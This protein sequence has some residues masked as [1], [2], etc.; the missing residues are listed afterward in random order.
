MLR[1]ANCK[2][3]LGLRVL[4]RRPDG[5]HDV[6]TAM[7]KVPWADVVDVVPAQGADDLLTVT[8]NPVDCPPEKNLVMKA[9]R[10]MRADGLTV[11]PVHVFLRKIV[12]DGAGLG[13]GSSDAAAT[14]MAVNDL[15]DLGLSADSMA[16]I[17]AKV[18]SDCPFFVYNTPMLATGT[19][20]DLRPIHINAIG[21]SDLTGNLGLSGLTIVIAKI[22]GLSVSTAQAYAGVT[23]DADVEPLTDILAL[24]VSKWQGRLINDFEP[25]VFAQLPAVAVLKQTML[26]NGAVYA[27]MSGSGSAV[28]GLFSKPFTPQT[29]NTLFPQALTFQATL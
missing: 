27:A 26:D 12:P 5:Y 8:G 11:P 3:N 13:G 28:F 20:T 2:I 4:R 7:V 6:E 21:D 17:L 24:P 18:G 19:G 25:S 14:V 16:A 1:F 10:A 29:L 15:F 22:P 9:V 23:P